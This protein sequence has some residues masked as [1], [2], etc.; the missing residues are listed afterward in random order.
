V[1]DI[2]LFVEEVDIAQTATFIHRIYQ[3]YWVYRTAIYGSD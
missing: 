2:D 1:T 3:H